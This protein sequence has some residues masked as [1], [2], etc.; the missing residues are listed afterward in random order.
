MHVW[1]DFMLRKVIMYL[2]GDSENCACWQVIQENADAVAKLDGEE[3]QRNKL[4]QFLIG[5]TMKRMKG[6]VSPQKVRNDDLILYF[7]FK[8]TNGDLVLCFNCTAR[9]DH[10]TLL[11]GYNAKIGHLI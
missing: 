7:T 2:N 1:L 8:V 5:Q 9:I 11:F 10:L 3:K 6:R 4:V